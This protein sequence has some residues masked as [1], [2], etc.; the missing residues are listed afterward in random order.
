MASG[1]HHRLDKARSLA[2][3]TGTSRCIAAYIPAYKEGD[4]APDPFK[5]CENLRRF[6]SRRFF[7]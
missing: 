5:M 3:K 7:S 1:W 4:R 6:P 2:K